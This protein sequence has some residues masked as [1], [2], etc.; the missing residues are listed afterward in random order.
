M[1]LI[2]EEKDIKD[3]LSMENTIRVVEAAFREKG[4]KRSQMPPKIYLFYNKYDGDLRIMSSYLEKL[5]I[6]G[7]KT[8]SVHPKNAEKYSLPTVLATI[9]LID[10]KTG[11]PQAIM[12]G[13]WITS[14]RTG[15]ASGVAT[16]YLAREDASI[17]GLI[18]SGVQARTQLLALS[19]VRKIKKVNVWTKTRAH[20]QKFVEEMK[21]K[22]QRPI[23]LMNTVEDTVK[24]ADIIV[25]ATP[26]REPILM[27]GWIKPG[28]HINAIGADAPG[29]EELDPAILKRAKVIVDDTI[30]AIHSGE[31]NV[32]ISKGIITEKDIY[33]ELGEV[34]AGKKKGRTSD[35]EITVF[36]ATGLSIEDIVT[37]NLVYRKANKIKRG[38]KIKLA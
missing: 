29:K 5:D 15:A 4:F 17:V 19:K 38:L 14:M 25:T 22:L 35:D 21:V 26:S 28:V 1:T 7:V 37:A 18:G 13:T 12:D 23:K 27:N 2:L 10:P 36:C 8:V 30:Q 31:I 34:V 20:G 32:P 33:C 16:K 9:I 24:E 6:S 3:L 11:A